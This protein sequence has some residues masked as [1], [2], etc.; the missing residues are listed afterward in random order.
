MMQIQYIKVLAVSKCL[1]INSNQV[2]CNSVSCIWQGKV[3]EIVQVLD[4]TYYMNIALQLAEGTMGQTSI[5]PVVG[6]VVVKDGRIVGLGAHLERGHAHAEVIAIQMASEFATDSVVYV[7]LEPCSH[8]GLTGPC[9][10]L[11][12][13]KRVSRVVV[14]MMDPNPQVAGRGIAMLR[15]A[16]IR[17]D[18]G[19]GEERAQLLNEVFCK[20]VT[21]R[22]PF[23]LAKVASTLDGRIATVTGDSQWVTGELARAHVH[24]L[25]HRVQAIMVG[26][27]TVLADDPQLSTRLTVPALQPVR[28]VADS[29]LRIPLGA[30]VLAEQHRQ[31]TIVL[32]TAQAP[33]SRRAELTAHGVEVLTCG[34]GPQVDL[35]LAMQRLGEREIGSLLLE[36]GSELNGAML[37]YRLIDKLMMFFAP[38]IIGGSSAPVNFNFTGIEHMKDAITI[39][40]MTVETVGSDILITGYPRYA[41]EVDGC[42]QE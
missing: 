13:R 29:Q 7:T 37:E 2:G 11:L 27:G 18:V 24:T 28:I 20:F 9:A 19:V 30:R 12:I 32:T 22:Q 17:V 1:E 38:K 41:K 39:E 31:S 14:A 42:L 4:D 3:G 25:R 16:G 26:V 35:R 34:D 10:D 40:R 33:A 6:C 5:N 21:T 15:A 36:G 8:Q 23:V